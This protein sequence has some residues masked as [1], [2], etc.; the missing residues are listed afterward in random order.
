[1]LMRKLNRKNCLNVVDLTLWLAFLFQLDSGRYT[2][3]F[4]CV[5]LTKVHRSAYLIYTVC[6]Y[7]YI[8]IYIVIFANSTLQRNLI[9]QMCILSKCMT[10]SLPQWELNQSLELVG[11]LQSLAQL[12]HMLY[13]VPS[14]PSY[15]RSVANNQVASPIAIKKLQN[16]TASH[17]SFWLLKVHN[18]GC[19]YSSS[20]FYIYIYMS[21]QNSSPCAKHLPSGWPQ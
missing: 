4:W 2:I 10:T 5:L 16:N 12:L 3:D 11:W 19:L 18:S 1:M 13:H 21:Y 8:Y 9:F 14:G 20:H 6:I 7:I 17:K 15:C